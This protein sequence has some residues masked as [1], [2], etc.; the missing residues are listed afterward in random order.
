MIVQYSAVVEFAAGESRKIHFK[1]L[2]RKSPPIDPLRPRNGIVE[3]PPN[4]FSWASRIRDSVVGLHVP[5]A[6]G[7][8]NSWIPVEDRAY[9]ERGIRP[10]VFVLESPHRD[11]YRNGDA[12]W[13]PIGPLHNR[14]H[15]DRHIC[16]LLREIPA[17]VGRAS[18]LL[19][20]PVPYQASLDRFMRGRSGRKVKLQRSVRNAIWR[21][22]FDEGFQADFKCRLSVYQPAAI[23]NAC[24]SDL[25]PF[26]KN[27]ILEWMN[28]ERPIP[29]FQCH[30]PSSWY[31]EAPHLLPV[32]HD[33]LAV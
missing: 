6:N 23:I 25:K 1:S 22:L 17:T 16:E 27:A 19:S 15:F 14:I 3:I 13:E 11:E 28:P 9:D 7:G 30:H 10:I 5:Q 26:V 12:R 24:T 8:A 18:L 20:N 29:M 32:A 2:H 4:H 21:T 33:P 31:R